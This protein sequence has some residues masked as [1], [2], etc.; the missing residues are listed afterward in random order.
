MASKNWHIDG[1][2]AEVLQLRSR[3]PEADPML[4]NN[5]MVG[6]NSPLRNRVFSQSELV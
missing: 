2:Y 3:L 6:P 4:V 5:P 1:R